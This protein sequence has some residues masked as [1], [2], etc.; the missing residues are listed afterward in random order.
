MLRSAR[1]LPGD[2]VVLAT[3]GDLAFPLA[4]AEPDLLAPL[5]LG[6]AL[7]LDAE[8]AVHELRE[9]LEVGPRLVGLLDRNRDIGV[10]LDRQAA[11]LLTVPFSASGLSEDGPGRLAGYARIVLH[12][13]DRLLADLRRLVAA[14]IL[15]LREPL[16]A[17]EVRALLR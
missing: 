5:E 6:V 12:L 8:H 7:L 11:R 3:V 4:R 9:L 13:L 15:E 16:V 10:A 14:A 1:R 17:G 2:A